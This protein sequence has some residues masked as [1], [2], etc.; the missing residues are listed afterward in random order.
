MDTL[1]HK[2]MFTFFLLLLASA[3]TAQAKPLC[4][5]PKNTQ[6]AIDQRDDY[7]VKCLKQKKSKLNIALCLSVAQ[8]MEYSTN[9]EDMRLFCLYNLE[10]TLKECIKITKTMEYPDTGDEARWECLNRFK[11]I[12]NNVCMKI[13]KSMSYPGNSQRATRYCSEELQ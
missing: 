12:S 10:T 2:L 8:S 1:K 11:N 7:R 13:A 6:L 3:I 9:A 5:L 4:E